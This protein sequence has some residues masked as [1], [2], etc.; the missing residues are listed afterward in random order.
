M[1]TSKTRDHQWLATDVWRRLVDL[2][3]G[4]HEQRRCV[5]DRLGLTYSDAKAL[6]TLDPAEAKPMRVL[7]SACGCDASNTT[8]MID[9]LED[10]GLVERRATATDR[11]VKLI[12]LTARGAKMREALL[13]GMYQ[14]PPDVLAL[15]R[16]DLAAVGAVLAKVPTHETSKQPTPAQAVPIV[17]RRPR[18]PG[19]T[20]R[21]RRSLRVAQ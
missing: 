16:E 17:K 10:R 2:F 9:R 11:R 19:R 6:Y 5:V 1:T 20:R 12:A 4:S 14:P 3:V 7:A 8:W 13:Q 21:A 15:S 18:P